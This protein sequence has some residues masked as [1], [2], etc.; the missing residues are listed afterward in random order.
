MLRPKEEWPP[1]EVGEL[2]YESEVEKE[3]PMFTQSTSDKLY[4]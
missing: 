3:K 4:E 2:E 1:A